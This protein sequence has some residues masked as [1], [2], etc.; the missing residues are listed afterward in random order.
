MIK[1]KLLYISMSLEKSNYGGSIVSRANLKALKTNERLEIKEI[2]I[3]RKEEGAYEWE[4][5][6]KNSKIQTAL[7]NLRGYAGRLNAEIFSRIKGIIHEY[8]P[9]T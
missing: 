9:T 6:A 5:L 4:M 1:E 7:N 8:Q 3:V 2:A